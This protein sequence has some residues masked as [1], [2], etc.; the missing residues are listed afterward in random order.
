[1]YQCGSCEQVFSKLVNN[2]CEYC[3]SGNWV[4]GNID[5]ELKKYSVCTSVVGF[6]YVEARSEQEAKLK[7]EDLVD[8][9]N[10]KDTVIAHSYVK[11]LG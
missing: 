7:V 9:H 5:G 1:M 11:E 2:E 6:Y 3:G 10:M 8:N 4:I